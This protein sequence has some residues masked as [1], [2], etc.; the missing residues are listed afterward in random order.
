VCARFNGMVGSS[1]RRA[2]MKTKTKNKKQKKPWLILGSLR[3]EEV[4]RK[5]MLEEAK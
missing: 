1:V 4:V 5:Y 2:L 3:K